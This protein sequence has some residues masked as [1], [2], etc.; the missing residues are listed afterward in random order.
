MIDY[1][2]GPKPFVRAFLRIKKYRIFGLIQPFVDTG[3]PI[4]VLSQVDADRLHVPFNAL[5]PRTP[6]PKIYHIGGLSFSGYPIEDFKLTMRDENDNRQE[7]VLNSVD[8]LKLTK[9]D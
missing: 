3:S 5:M 8:V 6:K 4:T 9:K 1:G 7:F 2:G